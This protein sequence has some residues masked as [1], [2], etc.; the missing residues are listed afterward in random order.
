MKQSTELTEFRKLGRLKDLRHPFLIKIDLIEETEWIEK[1]TLN[2]A[3]S[4]D[5]D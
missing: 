4:G 1:W 2:D 5:V 3:L